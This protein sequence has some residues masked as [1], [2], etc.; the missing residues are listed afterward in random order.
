MSKHKLLKPSPIQ[1]KRTLGNREVSF[2]RVLGW[3]RTPALIARA[4][5]LEL[6][7]LDAPDIRSMVKEETPHPKWYKE[8]GIYPSSFLCLIP[9]CGGQLLYV[10]PGKLKK[11]RWRWE[12]EHIPADSPV[13]GSSK[14]FLRKVIPDKKVPVP[15]A[16]V[17]VFC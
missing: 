4:G 14:S 9:C 15:R 10:R 2:Y 16:L 8:Y 1:G 13:H 7:L 12:F 11:G 3:Q 6:D 17:P 5:E